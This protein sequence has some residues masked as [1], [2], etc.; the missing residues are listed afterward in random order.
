MSPQLTYS[1][2]TLLSTEEKT[3]EILRTLPP[4]CGDFILAIESTTQPLTRYAYALD[5]RVFFRYLVSEVPLFAGKTENNFSDADWEEVTSENLVAYLNYLNLYYKEDDSF[6]T[7]A[8]LGKMRKMAAVRSF[9]KYLF[10]NK[11]ISRDESALVDMPKRHQKPIIRLEIDEVAKLLDAAESGDQLSERQKKYAERTRLRDVTILYL[12]LGT[13]MRVSELVGLDLQHID[14]NIN[15]LLVTRK[16]GNQAILYFPDEVADVLRAY[17]PYRRNLQAMPGHENALFL[18]LQKKRISVDAI[19]NMVKKYARI[20]APLKRKI[21]RTNSGRLWHEPV[22]RNGR[23]LPRGRRVGPCRRQHHA[24]ALRRYERRPPAHGQRAVWCCA[25]LP[26]QKARQR[27]TRRTPQKTRNSHASI[28]ACLRSFST[29]RLSMRDTCTWET[30][31]SL[32]I[33]VC[34]SRYT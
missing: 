1:Q 28:L 30:P 21:A 11:R 6:L 3:R 10:K 12:F 15:G 22:S 5:L 17:L 31:R 7:N 26:R 2:Q 25:S 32:A 27:Q 23:H 18:S 4:A 19:E 20:A 8:N 14:L 16:G 24:P 9:F 29:K 34:V 13:G 33:S